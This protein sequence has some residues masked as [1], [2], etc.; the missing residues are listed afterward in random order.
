MGLEEV[1]LEDERLK[2]PPPSPSTC[3]ALGSKG[4][5]KD[6]DSIS[7]TRVSFNV[8]CKTALGQHVGV[9]GEIPELGSWDA[10]KCLVLETSKEQYPLWNLTLRLPSNRPISFKYVVIRYRKNEKNVRYWEGS[11][12]RTITPQGADTILRDEFGKL[13]SK[14]SQYK[15][16]LTADSEIRFNIGCHLR[17]PFH[18][19]D[20]SIKNI[21]LKLTVGTYLERNCSECVSAEEVDVELRVLRLTF[22]PVTGE[23]IPH[24]DLLNQCE[25]GDPFLEGD[26]FVFSAKCPRPDTMVFYLNVFG[27]KPNADTL[28]PYLGSTCVVPSQLKGSRGS[29]DLALTGDHNAIIGDLNL[30]YLKAHPLKSHQ[31]SNVT[32]LWGSYWNTSRRPLDVGH[33]GMGNS[34]RTAMYKQPKV[35]ENT[36]ISFVVAAQQGA[37]MVEFDVQL[38]KD[39]VP[40]VY[41]NFTACANL[42]KK[43]VE[44]TELHDIKVSDLYLRQLQRLNLISSHEK[45]QKLKHLLKHRKKSFLEMMKGGSDFPSDEDLR[46]SFEAKKKKRTAEK[47]RSDAN[48]EFEEFPT[49]ERVFKEVPS[50]VA[51][52]IEIK[53]PIHHVNQ[54]HNPSESFWDINEYVDIILKCILDH[55]ENRRIVISCFE[56]DI[57]TLIRLKQPKFPM[58]FLTQNQCPKYTKVEDRRCNTIEEAV[59]F[60]KSEHLLGI[61]PN[62]YDLLKDPS[63]ISFAKNSNLVLFSWG[64]DNNNKENI[65]FQKEKGVDGVI[66]DRVD[67]L[68]GSNENIFLTEQYTL[69]K[70]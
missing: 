24:Y 65:R 43:G 8:T 53:F 64:D 7:Y 32:E 63:L 4:I 27:E 59:I 2:S 51:F 50:H 68:K 35:P 31:F 67:D 9:V 5:S 23:R 56:P 17:E 39:K 15:G 22:D 20:P 60:A 57:C 69:Q 29:L 48:C 55:S 66:Y 37:D 58:L 34:Q 54:E 47:Q 3:P 52:N 19:I 44:T 49:L 42:E 11:E 70:M 6:G 16:W 21:R 25:D 26:I 38:S 41:H 10:T 14:L 40:I 18:F 46:K 28:A 62:S 30:K 36:L 13:N 45:D 1:K 12:N 33:R 61:V